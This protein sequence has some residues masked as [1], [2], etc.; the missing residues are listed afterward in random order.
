MVRMA[1]TLIGIVFL[2][3][4]C[5]VQE[6]GSNLKYNIKGE[7][8]LQ[9]KK[10]AGGRQSFQAALQE[11]PTSAQANYYYA[12]FLLAEG[13]AKAALPYLQK[14]VQ[15]NPGDSDYHFWLGTA[16]GEN[17]LSKQERASYQAALRLDP[18]HG[19]A[20]TALGN[21]LLRAGELDKSFNLYQ[22]ALDI[23]PDNPQAM[24]N[25]AVI[26]RKLGREPEEKVAWREYLDSYPAGRFAIIATD[27]LNSL[28]DYAYRNYQLGA[29]TVT[30]SEITFVP[31]SAELSAASH[32]SLDLLGAAVANMK[33]GKLH[34]IVYQQNNGQLAKKRAIA[35]RHYLEK[36]FPQLRTHKRISLSWF[37]VPEERTV[38]GK[39]LA[40]NESVDLFLADAAKS[41]ADAG[42]GRIDL[43]KVKM[44]KKPVAEKKPAPQ[45][46]TVKK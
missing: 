23:W 32:P 18:K 33:K 21:N 37:D 26:L 7:Y 22:K 27:R 25:R 15:Y 12:R 29:R 45:K 9:E 43:G 13:E 5:A 38:L 4:G 1:A 8:Y 14:A 16:Y 42:T 46:K 36:K 2:L 3:S 31:L 10:Y 19:Q 39:K 34:I 30:L 17:D 28:G 35:I 44:E 6:F 24:Y 11:D 20:L 40:L 41:P